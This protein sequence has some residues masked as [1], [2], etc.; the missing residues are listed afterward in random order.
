MWSAGC[1]WEDGWDRRGNEGRR[2]GDQNPTAV[3]V[4]RAFYEKLICPLQYAFAIARIEILLLL[5]DR[6]AGIFN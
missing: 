2:T 5:A 3:A 1:G 4:W 6:D